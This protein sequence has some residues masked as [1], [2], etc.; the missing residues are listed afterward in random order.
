MTHLTRLR[1]EMA[2]RQL[3]DRVCLTGPEPRT[4]DRGD[5]ETAL[6]YRQEGR[7]GYG[8][9]RQRLESMSLLRD[10]S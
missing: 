7:A 1:G 6:R 8:H 4:G 5:Q 10:R 2:G 9:R 3:T